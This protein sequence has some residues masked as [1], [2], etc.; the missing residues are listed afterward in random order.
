MHKRDAAVCTECAGCTFVRTD[1]TFNDVSED[2]CFCYFFIL[3][4]CFFFFSSTRA[5]SNTITVHGGL[6]CG[7]D[8][9][10]R[11]AIGVRGGLPTIKDADGTKRRT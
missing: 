7:S 9:S 10:C 1:A 5:M 3:C 4:V 8:S 2:R 6:C 11:L